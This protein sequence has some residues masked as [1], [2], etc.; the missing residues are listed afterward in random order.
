MFMGTGEALNNAQYLIIN[1]QPHSMY[2]IFEKLEQIGAT[3]KKNNFNIPG[4]EI[5]GAQ[6]AI[7][8]LTYLQKNVDNFIKAEEEDRAS[9]RIK[10]SSAT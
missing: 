10:R 8:R 3:A 7:K 2:E 1:A 9:A 4:I 6:K 5:S